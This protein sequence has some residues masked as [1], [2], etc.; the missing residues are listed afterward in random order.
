M[1][2]DTRDQDLLDFLNKPRCPSCYKRHERERLEQESTRFKY[3][4]VF[5]LCAAI[6]LIFLL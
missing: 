3:V 1:D 5:L 6:A 4:L 2:K